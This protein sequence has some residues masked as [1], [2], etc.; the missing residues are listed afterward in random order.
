MGTPHC[1]VLK[2][3]QESLYFTFQEFSPKLILPLPSEPLVAVTAVSGSRP[4][5]RSYE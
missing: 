4:K 3:R 1:A 2:G 5:G